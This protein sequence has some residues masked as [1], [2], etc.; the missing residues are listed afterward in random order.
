MKAL[1]LNF[2]ALWVTKGVEI[3]VQKKSP[4]TTKVRWAGF[5]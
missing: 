2:S 1:F 5:V 3:D 4:P